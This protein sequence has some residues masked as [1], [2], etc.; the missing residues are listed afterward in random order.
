MKY[1]RVVKGD[2]H[3]RRTS[4]TTV[5]NELLT[6]KERKEMFPTLS[7]DCFEEVEV[8]KKNTYINFG[9]RFEKGTNH[10]GKRILYY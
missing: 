3:D 4:Y 9:V 1:L 2:V 5:T 8:S 7:D 10:N 6:A